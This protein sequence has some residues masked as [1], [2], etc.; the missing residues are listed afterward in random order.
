MGRHSLV[1]LQF[2]GIM[3]ACLL[4]VP[5]YM[6]SSINRCVICTGVTLFALVLH[7]LSANQNG[8]IF[9]MYINNIIAS[10]RLFKTVHMNVVPRSTM[11]T[12]DATEN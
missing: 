9:F 1:S 4:Y 10:T 12:N 11:N 6:V 7:L 3:I 5:D 2:S 8:A